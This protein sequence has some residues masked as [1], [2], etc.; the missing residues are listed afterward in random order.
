[1]KITLLFLIL[2]K[3]NYRKFS[4]IL[5]LK[6]VQPNVP[7]ILFLIKLPFGSTFLRNKITGK[8][9]C[10]CNFV[11]HKIRNSQMFLQ[12][13]LDFMINKIQEHL[14]QFYPKLQEH[15]AGFYE[16]QNYSNIRAKL[17]E[18]SVILDFSLK[19]S[20]LAKLQEHLAVILAFYEKKSYRNLDKIT[21]TAKWE[22]KFLCGFY[23]QEHLFLWETKS[24][25]FGSTFLRNKITENL[26]GFYEKQNYIIFG[27]FLWETKLQEHLAGF[28]RNKITEIFSS[29]YENQNYKSQKQNSVILFLIKSSQIFL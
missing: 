12:F 13:W 16:E 15:L 24:G 29:F 9:G 11:S 22:T 25:T 7:V 21:G 2:W 17:Q 4:C 6:K 5:F 19:I 18:H 1:M 28:L 8:L 23:L 3:Q 10:S 27:S 26:A 14:A 20:F